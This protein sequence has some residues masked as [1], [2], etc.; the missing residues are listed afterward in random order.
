MDA[1]A[2]RLDGLGRCS[3]VHPNDYRA[4]QDRIGKSAEAGES[5]RAVRGDFL[6]LDG[7]A[8]DHA[9]A[10]NGSA[11]VSGVEQSAHF[12]IV[13]CLGAENRIYFIVEDC[14]PPIFSADLTEEIGRRDVD[15]L[16]G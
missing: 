11:P 12:L 1:A 4:G 6:G 16:D 14:R 2:I 13:F 5:Y 10:R 7:L 3:A 9:T 15:G 8:F